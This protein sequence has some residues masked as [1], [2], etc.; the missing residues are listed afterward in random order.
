[1]TRPQILV[2]MALVAC[3]PH[4]VEAMPASFITHATGLHKPHNLH[5]HFGGQCRSDAV[6]KPI[7]SP[8]SLKL[9]SSGAAGGDAQRNIRQE[10]LSSSR[11]QSL[12]QRGIQISL[13]AA[14]IFAFERSIFLLGRYLGQR[15]PS[16]PVGMLLVFLILLSIHAFNPDA[17]HR[18]TQ[19]FEP[20]L[21]F[22]NKGVPLFFSPPLVQLPLSLGAIPFLSS[23]KLLLV[24]LSGT[25]VSMILT[26]LAT[27]F[28]V[29]NSPHEERPKVVLDPDDKET[30]IQP[31]EKVAPKTSPVLKAAMVMTVVSAIIQSDFLFLIS[32]SIAALQFGKTFSPEIR[33]FLPAIITCSALTSSMVCA[34]GWLRLDGNWVA[35]LQAYKTSSGGILG[36]TGVGDVTFALAAPAIVALG[37]RLYEQRY[38]L[39]RNIIPMLGGSA[40]TAVLSVAFTALASKLIRLPS[41]LGLSLVTRFVTLPM[42]VPIVES[43]GANLGIAALAVCLQGILGAT[44]GT[45]LL[46]LVGVRDTI[47][48]G[49]AMGGTSHALGTASVA[50][51]EP[52]ISP[53]SAVTFLLSGSFMVAFMQVTFIR[54]F[55]VALFA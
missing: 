45:K 51:S 38:L 22:Y 14:L 37:F 24:I 28:L 29:S 19:W 39:K 48:R 27:N 35:A 52:K 42:A 13:G 54:N 7:R 49:V 44:F 5:R 8:S 43:V 40:I 31:L 2:G 3:I 21:L 11:F 47:A 53:P 33:T 9:Q 16:A 17:S 41:E 4:S 26:G 46:D 20:S 25:V 18:L 36:G 6:C 50:S 23:A 55:V 34:L 1:M 15:I 10:P 30:L 32:F 12:M